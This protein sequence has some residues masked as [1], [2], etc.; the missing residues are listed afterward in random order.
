[1]FKSTIIVSS[2][3]LLALLLSF[4]VN[5]IISSRFGTSY[6]LDCYGV[7][8][9]IPGFISIVF[10]GIISYT[11]IP[12]FTEY[13]QSNLAE[14]W[15]VINALITKLFFVLLVVT[16][17][18]IFFSESIIEIISPGFD[19]G[20]KTFTSELLSIYFPIIIFT[21]INELLA[22]IYY[23]F[24]NFS[25]PLL[26]KLITPLLTVIFVLLWSKQLSVKS[27][28]ISSLIGAVIQFFILWIQITRDIGFRFFP[29]INL[30]HPGLI[31]IFKLMLPLFLSSLL[32]KIFPI[33]DSFLLSKMEVGSISKINY[34][35]KLQINIGI[36]VTSIFSVQVLSSLSELVSKGNLHDFK[37][38]ISL[39]VRLLLYISIPMSILLFL[40]SSKIIKTIYEHGIFTK[41]DTNEVSHYF[42][43]YIIAL[44]AVSI[45][46]II[47]NGLYSLQSTKPVMLIG[48][49]ESFFY[50]FT[51]LTLIQFFG[52]G[53][54]PIAYSINFYVSVLVLALILRSKIKLGGGQNLIKYIIKITI[55]SLITFYPLY[56]VSKNFLNNDIFLMIFLIINF[57][58]YFIATHKLKINEFNLI[59]ENIKKVF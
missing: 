20:R 37:K 26:N 12:I 47:S 4:S 41:Y 59:Y 24:G 7:A 53:T 36:L 30:R 15:K 58:V 6:E 25:R 51:C 5:I 9:T 48:V 45:G 46:A 32:T 42:K 43:Y 39:Y 22:S 13:K 10:S 33:F 3:N 44:P 55:I 52:A 11:V 23:S 40:Y 8:I 27:I 54:I 28:L 35:N 14:G 38:R 21:I 31:K 29:I 2:L 49:F 50:M 34:A 56:T 16:V 19:K 57:M 18:G 1:M 17:L